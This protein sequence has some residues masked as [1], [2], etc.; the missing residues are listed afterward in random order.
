MSYP[1]SLLAGSFPP[2]GLASGGYMGP[3]G[4]SAW[5]GGMSPIVEHQ[6]MYRPHMNAPNVST[7]QGVQNQSYRG[8]NFS[9]EH[10]R[11]SGAASGAS[12]GDETASVASSTA[13]EAEERLS[14]IENMLEKLTRAER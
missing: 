8:G 1:P 7:A 13:A 3:G 12:G 5:A 14:R 9:A 2:G 11:F 6:P 10:G 4:A